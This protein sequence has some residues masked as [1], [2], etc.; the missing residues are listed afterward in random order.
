MSKKLIQFLR[1]ERLKPLV[2]LCPPKL[3]PPF[4]HCPQQLRYLARAPRP[5]VIDTSAKQTK[6][7]IAA[8]NSGRSGVARKIIA[9]TGCINLSAGRAGE[10]IADAGR[11]RGGGRQ[12]TQYLSDWLIRNAICR[13]AFVDGTKRAGLSGIKH[14]RQYHLMQPVGLFVR[15]L[16]GF[17]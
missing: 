14:T 7:A 15:G 3:K 11:Q 6:N 16:S 17:F 9:R 5:S 10:K 1:Q 2:P 8:I 4:F 12:S 13:C